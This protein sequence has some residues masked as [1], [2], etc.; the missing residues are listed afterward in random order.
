MYTLCVSVPYGMVACDSCVARV[1]RLIKR[2][3]L[4]G[5]IGVTWLPM[6]L[7]GFVVGLL[8]SEPDPNLLR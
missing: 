5:S 8:K 6:P 2:G 4:C 3:E 1:G 7:G